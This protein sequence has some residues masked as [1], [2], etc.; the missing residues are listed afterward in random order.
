MVLRSR[1]WKQKSVRQRRSEPSVVCHARQTSSGAT[2]GMPGYLWQGRKDTISRVRGTETKRERER[3]VGEPELKTS[4][5]PQ[6]ATAHH[7]LA[8]ADRGGQ[9]ERHV[10]STT[11]RER[12]TLRPSAPTVSA[13]YP[14]FPSLHP[15][16]PDEESPAR[17]PA[18]RNRTTVS[19]RERS[20]GRARASARGSA[21][22]RDPR[23]RIPRTS[24]RI[25]RSNSPE[26]H[27]APPRANSCEFY[28]DWRA[29]VVG[30]PPYIFLRGLL[31]AAISPHWLSSSAALISAH[32]D[33]III[34]QR[35]YF[36]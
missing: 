31:G 33:G 3:I 9:V 20:N 34:S 26:S 4:L 11:P 6:S 10:G 14:F 21:T 24:G 12:G 25:N 23:R 13:A 5:P 8:L 18:L 19:R 29:R 17:P 36:D 1:R 32:L 27:R 28:G 2:G 22:S 30:K 15:G 7:R 35:K 16:H